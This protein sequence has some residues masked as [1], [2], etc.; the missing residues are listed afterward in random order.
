MDPIITIA[1]L[2]TIGSFLQ[3][4]YVIARPHFKLRARYVANR[5]GDAHGAYT[6]QAP[7]RAAVLP[8]LAPAAQQPTDPQS[9]CTT[10][11]FQ[12]RPAISSGMLYSRTQNLAREM[13]TGSDTYR[14]LA[15]TVYPGTA[16]P[17]RVQAV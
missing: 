17:L 5:L 13:W 9:Q 4:V 2:L 16:A 11:S 7:F 8:V 14:G 12:P 10:T 15:G 1:T 3:H 6:A